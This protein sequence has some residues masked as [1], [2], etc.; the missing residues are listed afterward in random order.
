MLEKRKK[1]VKMAI[2][3][4]SDGTVPVSFLKK[5]I[6]EGIFLW[7]N[8][9]TPVFSLEAFEKEDFSQ[10]RL[11]L[12]S[13]EITDEKLKNWGMVP[14]RGLVDANAQE[15]SI[16]S[17]L[18][19][20]EKKTKKEERAAI[21]ITCPFIYNCD[22]ALAIAE[23]LKK[24]L[25]LSSDQFMSIHLAVHEALVNGL[26]HGNLE[27]GSEYRQSLS[28]LAE[29]G[30]L[31]E[32]RLKD[33]AYAKKSVLIKAKWNKSWLD[34]KIKDEGAGYAVNDNLSS[35]PVK[36][37]KPKSGRGLFMIAGIAD[38]CTID[39]FGREIK[40]SF[41]LSDKKRGSAYRSFRQEKKDESA[42]DLSGCKV[43][44]IEDNKSNQIMIQ[45]LLNVIGIHSI[46]TAEDGLE[47][48]E[49]VKKFNPD[50]IILDITM[51]RM[52][53]YEVL[54]MLKSEEETKDIPVLIETASDTREAR[55]KTF[56]AG[57]TDFITKPINPLEFF[58]RVKVHLENK[59]LVSKLEKQLKNIKRELKAAHEMQEGIL[60]SKEALQSIFDVYHVNVQTFFKSSSEIGGDAY[61]FI[62]LTE[63]KFAFYICDFSGH[64]VSAALNTFRL[65]AL[66]H[67]MD[68][69]LFLNPNEA[70]SY[71]NNQLIK[72]LPRGQFA[73]FFLGLIDVKNETLKYSGAG[74][75]RPFYW[76]EKEEFHL[77]DTSGLPLG[78]K[79]NTS[80][81]VARL[82]FV[83]GIKL[84]L[85]SDSFIES[86]YQGEDSMGMDGFQKLLYSTLKEEKTCKNVVAKISSDFLKNTQ[87]PLFDDATL[88]FMERK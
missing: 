66:I 80:Y 53:G 10:S 24:H 81:E 57:A 40:F 73:T 50:L 22:I 58:S 29:Y 15:S 32:K 42:S 62:P 44:V 87:S 26:I 41:S 18:T 33:P 64:G 25:N 63:D 75:P 77:I 84:L 28:M 13:N 12:F 83:K 43:L 78:I 49:K 86:P 82:P 59:L 54:S 45:R 37:S 17:F 46:K 21:L 4:T 5:F 34:V 65:D 36:S 48:L 16:S 27:I 60:P 76:M 6:R 11:I 7:P 35:C 20:E 1:G 85:F 61:D 70:L 23:Y 79:H 14:F 3:I 52:D 56:S 88:L 74:I 55:D 68:L 30:T 38:S 72:L 31:L 9:Q 39:D 69:N 19:Y 2:Y 67:Q 47:G 71:L 51:P 8:E